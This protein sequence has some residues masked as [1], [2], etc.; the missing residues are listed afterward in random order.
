[1][2]SRRFHRSMPARC[3]RRP[4]AS[5]P[6]PT[7]GF[8]ACHGPATRCLTTTAI[9]MRASRS[10]V[11]R[12]PSAP[13]PSWP[14]PA[15]TSPCRMPGSAA[16]RR[17]ASARSSPIARCSARECICCPSPA[18]RRSRAWPSK[19]RPSVISSAS[20]AHGRCGCS[21]SE[22]RRSTCCSG[23]P[24]PHAPT[25]ARRAA[26]GSR[27]RTPTASAAMPS[28]EPCRSWPP[29]TWWR[30]PCSRARSTSARRSPASRG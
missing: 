18:P 19:A 6:G 12:G 4:G 17:R 13:A 22:P 9:F 10:S 24:A 8:R 11:S 5:C 15:S 25:R 23:R 7:A 16:S 29:P 30:V 3:S 2:S 1:M 21:S 20:G 27:S 14:T 28:S 26:S